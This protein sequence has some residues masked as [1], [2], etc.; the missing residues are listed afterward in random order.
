M[1]VRE[2]IKRSDSGLKT[3]PPKLDT[4]NGVLSTVGDANQAL[5]LYIVLKGIADKFKVFH[6]LVD[7]Q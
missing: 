7:D 5:D 2:A 4:V 1:A 3:S 6:D